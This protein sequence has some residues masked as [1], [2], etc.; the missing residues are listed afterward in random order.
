MELPHPSDP[1]PPPASKTP[2]RYG[3]ACDTCRRRRIRCDCGHPCVRCARSGISCTYGSQA[4]RTSAVA[5]TRRLEQKVADLQALLHTR[6]DTTQHKLRLSNTGRYVEE[7]VNMM[8]GEDD[9][10]V[11]RASHSMN[12]SFYGHLSG[13]NVMREIESMIF[14]NANRA[15]DDLLIQAF[16]CMSLPSRPSRQSKLSPL[17]PPKAQVKVIIKHATA[18]GLIGHDCLDHENLNEAVDRLYEKD[19]ERYE[20]EDRKQLALIYALVALGKRF[21]PMG[22]RNQTGRSLPEV[23]G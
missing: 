16:D 23:R 12:P 7:I 11:F 8:V 10:Y 3:S 13:L 4:G 5:Y 21:D 2:G 19:V 1:S 20:T 22:D 14:S 15:S 18:T 17:L 9:C 6:S